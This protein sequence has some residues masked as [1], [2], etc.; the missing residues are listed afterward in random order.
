[1][2]H[3]G[4]A[5]QFASDKLKD[6]KEIVLTAIQNYEGDV[7]EYASER[8]KDDKETVLSAV[9]R[10]EYSIGYASE[11]LRHDKD[12]IFA[13]LEAHPGQFENLPEDVQENLDYILFGLESV[14]RHLP[15]PEDYSFFADAVSEYYMDFEQAEDDFLDI[16]ESI[17]REVLRAD[18]SL[19]DRVSLLAVEMNGAYYSEGNYPYEV[20]HDRLLCR[21]EALYEEND[22]PVR[23]VLKEA[24]DALKRKS[25]EKK[26]A[27]Y[28][29]L[30]P[31]DRLFYENLDRYEMI[32]GSSVLKYGAEDNRDYLS[33]EGGF[34]R[35]CMLSFV[36]DLVYARR[37]LYH[38]SEL[39]E[40]DDY[41]V[42][43][44][45]AYEEI[46]ARLTPELRVVRN[47]GE[48]YY[49]ENITVEVT[50]RIHL[51]LV[52]GAPLKILKI[53]VNKADSGHEHGK[54]LTPD[55]LDAFCDMIE[56][57]RG[58]CGRYERIAGQRAAM[59][60]AK[61]GL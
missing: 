4:Y 10:C 16:L 55:R 42:D 18:P 35:N 5:L 52:R 24:M 34:V 28:G 12:V 15:D 50:D 29:R 6:D 53:W 48:Y 22:I 17:P 3:D 32:A 54:W 21:M 23:P 57:I 33:P 38:D 7:L 45:K 40:K 13:V 8:L 58:I 59:L 60:R 14:V 2:R 27:K 39:W 20:V 37:G 11:R 49:S 1:V 51:I 30:D 47:A 41:E 44:D 43:L 46:S 26:E 61:F 31:E 56:H 19:N 25:E 36:K 9:G